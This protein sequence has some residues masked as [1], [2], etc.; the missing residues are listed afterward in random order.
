LWL[1]ESPLDRFLYDGA[2]INDDDTPDSLDMEDNGVLII[3]IFHLDCGI[4]RAFF[5]S[6][7]T[8]DVM[9]ERK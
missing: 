6:S 4:H 3:A 9:V 1:T 2:R 8:I 7:D 5:T